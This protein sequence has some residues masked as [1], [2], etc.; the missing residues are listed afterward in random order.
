[1]LVSASLIVHSLMHA[2]TAPSILVSNVSTAIKMGDLANAA[3]MLTKYRKQNGDTP[4][5]VEAL[6]WIA[7]GALSAG[8]LDRAAKE[9]EETRRLCQTALHGKAL[10]ADAHL[11]MAMGAALEVEAQAMD[12][13]HQ[14]TEA[15]GL[16][17]SALHTWHGSSIMPRLQKNLNLLTMQGKPIPAL[18]ESE[19]IGAKPPGAAALSHK[20]V[21][22]FFWAHWCPDCKAEAPVLARLQT[23]LGARGLVTIAPTKRY[24]YTG[25]D[26]APSAAK[27]K[28]YIEKI[29][30]K[31][32]AKIPGIAVPLDAANFDRFGASTTPTLVI[33]DRHGIVRLYHPGVL[34][35]AALRSA[36]EPLL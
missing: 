15:I 19:W 5:A 6:S 23:S 25:D 13:R 16:L 2:Q 11:A 22:L 32:Y 29:F 9:A 14:K 21:L 7:R 26:D 12:A 30:A 8:D 3:A 18:H 4:E 34:E 24:G 17:Q 27:E 20:V 33:A 1:M 31:Y 35:E 10:D 28:E 36:I